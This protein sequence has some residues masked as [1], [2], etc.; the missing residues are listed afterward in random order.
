MIDTHSHLNDEQFKPD[1]IPDIISR[2]KD[3]GVERIVVCGYDMESSRNA[4]NMAAQ[5]ENIYATVGVHPHDSKDY[6]DES[7]HELLE[8]SRNK[9]VIAIGEIGLDFHYNFSPTAD[10]FAAFD[11][12]IKLASRVGLPIV[13]HSRESNAESLQVLKENAENIVACVYH[14]FSGDEEFAAEILDM[15][16]YIGIDGP[17]TYKASAKLRR[18]ISMYP[19]DKILLETDCPYLSPIPYRGKRNEPAYVKYIAEEVSRVKGMTVEELAE[20]TSRNAE[21]LFPKLK[22]I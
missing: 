12:Q 22:S 20:I 16:F 3:A 8:L 1:E 18:V 14:C 10:Q 5:Y 11:A 9:K 2:A 7:E 17:V 4:V 15:G 13:I 6:D 19:I 21:T